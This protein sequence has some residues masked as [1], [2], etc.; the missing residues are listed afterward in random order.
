MNLSNVTWRTIGLHAASVV[1]GGWATLSFAASHSVDLYA[2]YDQ[3]NVVIADVSKLIAT[4]TVPLA[5][6]YA[7]YKSATKSLL[8]DAAAIPEVRGIV[9]A[10]PEMARAVPSDKVQPSVAELPAAAKVDPPPL[11]P[12]A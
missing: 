4:A 10:T 11:G 1:A 7:A 9:V 6:L 5:G 12:K 3:L 8:A 2:I